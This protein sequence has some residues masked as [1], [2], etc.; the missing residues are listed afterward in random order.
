MILVRTLQYKLSTEQDFKR[1][2][3]I[4]LIADLHIGL[5]SGHERQLK[6]IVHK[7]NQQ[8]PDCVVV[9]GD[10]T[11]EPE[12]KL[13]QELSILKEIRERIFFLHDVGLGYITL[14]RD[15]RTISGGEAQRIRVAS[16][17]GSGLTGV[18]YV[19]DEPSI[20]LHERDTNKLIKTTR[21]FKEL[22]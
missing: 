1:P 16:Q 21:N 3:R 2:I 10:W 15:A 8:N 4:A 11:Y 22:H 13:E 17:I 5:F 14:G 9:A 12:N 6:S 19:L 20:G 7:I 18:M